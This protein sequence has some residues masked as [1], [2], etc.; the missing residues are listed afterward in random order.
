MI[1]TTLSTPEDILST[2][3]DILSTPEDIGDEVPSP[4]G[5]ILVSLPGRHKLLPII[6]KLESHPLVKK[7]HGTIY[8]GVLDMSQKAMEN[9]FAVAANMALHNTREQLDAK[10]M[11]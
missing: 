5:G 9:L 10:G 4:E 7:P 8:V 2:P 3:E 1:K 11:G 6:Y